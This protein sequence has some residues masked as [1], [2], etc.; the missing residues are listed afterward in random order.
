M[1]PLFRHNP[2]KQFRTAASFFLSP[3]T[4]DTMKISFF[5]PALAVFI[6]SVT[7]YRPSHPQAFDLAPPCFGKCVQRFERC[8]E[9]KAEEVINLTNSFPSGS[10]GTSALIVVKNLGRRHVAESL[11]LVPEFEK[12][13]VVVS[14]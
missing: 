9:R 2:S 3:Q 13:S 7:A 5:V 14:E 10:S 8:K 11:A 1:T 6:S 12:M 4:I